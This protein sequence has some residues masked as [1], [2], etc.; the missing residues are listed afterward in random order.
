VFVV[1]F[2]VLGPLLGLGA[3]LAWL[4]RTT[5]LE[6][7]RRPV[8]GAAMAAAAITVV[9]TWGIAVIAGQ[10]FG[11]F[12]A[13]EVA[14]FIAEAGCMAWIVVTQTTRRRQLVLGMITIA[15]GLVF[16]APGLVVQAQPYVS[17]ELAAARCGHQPVIANSAF[18]Y[19]SGADTYELPGDDG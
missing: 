9:V 11:T 7:M 12:V 3:G 15:V 2:L 8:I 4:A 18:G 1:L 6:P 10:P 19:F 5:Y 17:F 13:I 16:I 14:I